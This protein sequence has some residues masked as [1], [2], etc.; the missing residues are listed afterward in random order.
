MPFI[1]DMRKHPLVEE[2]KLEGKLEAAKAMIQNL[3]LN[4]EEVAKILKHDKQQIKEALK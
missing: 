3:H 1:I 4:I 2:A